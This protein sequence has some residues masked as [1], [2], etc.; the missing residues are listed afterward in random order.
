MD[1]IDLTEQEAITL[2][3]VIEN[4]LSDLHTEISHTDDRDFRSALKRRQEL[5]QGILERLASLVG[6]PA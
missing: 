5:L 3:D 4:Y 6:Q 1:T 2:R